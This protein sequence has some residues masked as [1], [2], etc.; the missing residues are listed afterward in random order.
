MAKN[1]DREF[2]NAVDRWMRSEFRDSQEAHS[3]FG[4]RHSKKQLMVEG[5]VENSTSNSELHI[6]AWGVNNNNVRFCAGEVS[7]SAEL[8][9]LSNFNGFL[10]RCGMNDA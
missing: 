7:G 4:I 2:E 6:K 9:L 5:K 1:I 3:T 8:G 10:R